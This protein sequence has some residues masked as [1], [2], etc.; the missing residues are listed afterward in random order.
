LIKQQFKKSPKTH[1]LIHTSTAPTI[2][3]GGT[4]ENV[5]PKKLR[6]VV[7]FRVLPGDTVE[8]VINHTR[9]VI[10]DERVII[11]PLKKGW[12]PSVVSDSRS[13]SFCAL[14]KT[15]HQVFPETVIAPYLVSGATDSRHYTGLTR[16]VYRFVPL[17]VTDEDLKRV[18]G[19]NERISLDD[20]GKFVIF[21]VQMIRN[22]AL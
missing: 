11:Q 22:S 18:H 16:N 8:A 9:S 5:L 19:V 3:E 12:E 1:A 13:P 2:V 17:R 4:K 6:A 10:A 7:N 21:Y 20:Y 14:R 15:I